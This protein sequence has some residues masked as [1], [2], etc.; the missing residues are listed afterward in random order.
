[1]AAG[2]AL[3]ERLASDTGRAYC[4]NHD[5]A[6]YEV[7]AHAEIETQSAIFLD[8]LDTVSNPLKAKGV[9]ELRISGAAAAIANAAYNGS[10]VCV[11]DYTL[12]VDKMIAQSPNLKQ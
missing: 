12:T 5:L 8:T 4:V 1:M 3:P 6:S 9:G 7:P 2:V 11:R 10:G